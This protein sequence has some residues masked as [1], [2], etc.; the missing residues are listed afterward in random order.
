MNERAFRQDAFRIAGVAAVIFGGLLILQMV[1]YR[2]TGADVYTETNWAGTFHQIVDHKLA[3]SISAA[4]GALAA[5]CTIPLVLG[6]WF[7]VEEDDRP[8]ASVAC[9]FLLLSAIIL[10][11]GMAHYGNLVGTS[12]DYINHLAPQDVIIQNGDSIGDTFQIMQYGGFTF[13]GFGLLIMARL[14]DRSEVFPK[15]LAWFSALVGV[16]SLCFNFLPAL[17][18]GG[19]LAWVLSMGFTWLRAA[20]QPAEDAESVV[21]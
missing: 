13:F 1:S 3:F 10:V 12:F 14:M 16:S 11:D 19:R 21:I 8:L 17:F 20:P 2:M 4:S 15:S 6:F 5:A 7:S 18:I 9:G